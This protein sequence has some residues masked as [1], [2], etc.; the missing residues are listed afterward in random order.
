MASCIS[1]ISERLFSTLNSRTDARLPTEIGHIWAKGNSKV[2]FSFIHR[3]VSCGNGEVTL[4][5]ISEYTGAERVLNDCRDQLFWGCVHFVYH[6]VI[7][8]LPFD[9]SVS[10]VEAFSFFLSSFCS[11][12]N[13]GH[14][15]FFCCSVSVGPSNKE[16][17]DQVTISPSLLAEVVGGCAS[18]VIW[19]RCCHDWKL[20]LWGQLLGSRDNRWKVTLAMIGL[21]SYLQ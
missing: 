21:S 16:V 6:C 19:I 18:A 7:F 13:Q 15:V 17:V 14:D 9:L 11:F 10:S 20:S 8:F 1:Y 3:H 12:T 2:V 4:F 5:S